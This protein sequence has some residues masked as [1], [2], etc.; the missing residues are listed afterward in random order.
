[1]AAAWRRG[2]AARRWVRL[3][4]CA[5]GRQRAVHVT[6]GPAASWSLE[7]LPR[8]P[9]G[10]PAEGA[11]ADAGGASGGCRQ[12]S[13]DCEQGEAV[14]QMGCLIRGTRSL[15]FPGAVGLR[16]EVPTAAAT[17]IFSAV[18]F[19]KARDS[20]QGPERAADGVL[21]GSGTWGDTAPL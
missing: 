11:G 9:G 21:P 17:H 3:R 18:S 2:S 16:F 12:V 1:M 8:V 4:C 13:P 15:A 10:C 19:L 14:S 5:L 20:V 7:C 6:P